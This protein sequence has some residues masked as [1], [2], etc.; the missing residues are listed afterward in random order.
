[1]RTPFVAGN[2]KMN[3][4]SVA[5]AESLASDLVGE[6][7]SIGGVTR[8]ACPPFV[9]LP[10]VAGALASSGIGVGAQNAHPEAKGA[11]TG[12]VPLGMLDGLCAYVIVGHSETAATLRRDGRIREREGRRRARGGADAHPLRRR[13]ARRARRAQGGGG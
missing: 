8:V 9:A 10:A 2:W 13:D 3:P 11:F 12:E 1:M 4:P 7:G 6:I 5:E